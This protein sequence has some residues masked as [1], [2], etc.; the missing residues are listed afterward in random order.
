MLN[1]DITCIADA[2][3]YLQKILDNAPAKTGQFK[4][5]EAGCGS[6]TKL[7]FSDRHH[8]TGIDISQKQLD[9]NKSVH[10]KVLGDIQVYQF[11]ES[12]FDMIVCWHVLEH[13]PDPQRALNLFFSCVK[14]QGTIVITSP[15]PLS[16]KGVVTKFTPHLFHVFIYRYIYGRKDAGTEDKAPFEA[17]MRLAITPE[18]ISKTAAP[19]GLETQFIAKE[20]AFNAHSWVGQ[21]FKKKSKVLYALVSALRNFLWLISFGKIGDSEYIIVLKKT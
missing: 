19:F 1:S 13:L 17:H 16:L 9:R 5:L 7:K 21:A 2:V 10:E 18:N 12:S 15:N 14:K 11:P 3:V 8:I 6:I 4:V 20:D